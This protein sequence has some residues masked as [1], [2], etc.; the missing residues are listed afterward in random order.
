NMT[1]ADNASAAD[2]K[3]LRC[4]RQIPIRDF[5]SKSGTRIISLL[6]PIT[7]RSSRKAFAATVRELRKVGTS[8]DLNRGLINEV[9][10]GSAR[11]KCAKRIRA[12]NRMGSLKSM[13]RL[14]FPLP[15]MEDWRG[16]A[17]PPRKHD[18]WERLPVLFRHSK[19]VAVMQ[20][21]HRLTDN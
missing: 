20:K 9:G 6:V 13:R 16:T 11:A 8:A 18:R 10:P 12:T 1:N 17:A 21:V 7:F 5:K 19:A 15:G 2:L 4:R 14:D 3:S